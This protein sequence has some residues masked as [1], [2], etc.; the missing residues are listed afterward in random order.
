MP[1]NPVIPLRVAEFAIACFQELAFRSKTQAGNSTGTR[2]TAGRATRPPSTVAPIANASVDAEAMT[3]RGRPSSATVIAPFWSCY[4]IR[5][6]KAGWLL[7]AQCC[8]LARLFVV[9]PVH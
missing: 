1:A 9:V 6:V 5:L 7:F 3:N 2:F 4:A 8:R